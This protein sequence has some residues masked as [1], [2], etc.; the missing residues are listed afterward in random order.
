MTFQTKIWESHPSKYNHLGWGK[1][2]TVAVLI[3]ISTSSQLHLTWE[4]F[5]Y[6][7]P[8]EAR[9]LKLLFYSVCAR[10]GPSELKN[11]SLLYLNSIVIPWPFP[12]C[13]ISR[14]GR[15]GERSSIRILQGTTEAVDLTTSKQLSCFLE[16][17]QIKKR[18]LLLKL[19]RLAREAAAK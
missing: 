6:S 7:F 14:R 11:K 1:A 17:N 9:R 19:F 5:L 3:F 4:I 16:S 8:F 2:V 10:G 15:E 12:L 13:A 18:L